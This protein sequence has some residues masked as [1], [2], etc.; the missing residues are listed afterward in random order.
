MAQNLSNPAARRLRL[1]GMGTPVRTTAVLGALL[2]L[3][4]CGSNSGAGIGQACTAIG[5]RVGVALDV[6][7][8]NVAKASLRVCW[9]DRCAT[10]DATLYPSS[11]VVATTCT[12]TR[13]D[14][15]CGAQSEPNGEQNAFG[16]I[17]DLPTKLVTV[18]VRLTDTTGAVVVDQELSLTPKTVFP[19]GPDCPSGGPQAGVVVDA[20]GS[21]QE[22]S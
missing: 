11:H 20:N 3:G 2:V 15:S 5:V 9:D 21:V 1:I 6:K 10:P 4:A 12:G 22:R 7:T 14:D 18:T 13:P 16:D 8:P 17:P 19:N